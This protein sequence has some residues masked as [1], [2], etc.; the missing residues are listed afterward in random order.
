[1]N[2]PL[3]TKEE[4]LAEWT[5]EDMEALGYDAKPC[6]CN[7]MFGPCEGWIIT[8]KGLNA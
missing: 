4:F 6:T 5:Q 3:K 2:K 7:E 1:M 8:K